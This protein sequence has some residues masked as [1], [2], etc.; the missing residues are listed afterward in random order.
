[1][2]F[3]GWPD[4][5]PAWHPHEAAAYGTYA[6]TPEEE[7]DGLKEH[8]EWLKGELDAISKRIEELSGAEA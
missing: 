2:G 8:A 3:A 1:M 5:G 6:P 7:L 4:Y